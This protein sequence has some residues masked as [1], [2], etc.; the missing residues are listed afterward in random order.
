MDLKQEQRLIVAAQKGDEQAFGELYDA[1]VDKVYRYLAFRVDNPDTAR[2]LT[3]E[4][5]LRVVEGLPGYEDRGRTFLAWLYRIA[6]AR[7]IDYYRQNTHAA[8]HVSLEDAEFRIGN[9]TDDMDMGLMASYRQ[10]QV[11]EALRTLTNDQ[12][13]VIW[14]RF[15]EGHNLEET[16]M[17]LGKTVG[18]IKLLQYRAVQ[19]LSRALSGKGLTFT[20]R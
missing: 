8:K 20:Q 18:A 1:F 14:L 10:E 5:F 9:D 11:R 19:S 13:Q 12:Q 2:D 4:V 16:A 15:M 7:L 3:A 17:L 6:H